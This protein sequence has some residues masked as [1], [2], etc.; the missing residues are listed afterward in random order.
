MEARKKTDLEHAKLLGPVKQVMETCYKAHLR[1]GDV[2]QGKIESDLAH[3]SK[4]N[5]KTYNENGAK[6]HEQLFGSDDM[7][8]NTF[9][10]EGHQTESIHYRNGKL[11]TTST[12]TFNEHGN[13][14]DH[15]VR[16][17]DGSLYFQVIS[18]Y[19][20]K[21]KPLESIHYMGD[22]RKI[23]SRNI[24]TY[25]ENGDMLTHIEYNGEGKITHQTIKTYNKEGKL[26]D[27]NSEYTEEKKFKYN[28]RTT[29]KYN[30]HGDTIETA[31]HK[32]D[33]SIDSVFRYSYT[34]NKL[35]QCI[36][37]TSYD[38]DGS[39][40]YVTQHE[41]DSEGKRII[42]PYEYDPEG[43]KTPGE[44]DKRELDAHGNW[45]KKTTFY[46]KLP[47]N[48]YVRQ[49]NYFGEKQE[50]FVH[51]LA[52]ATDEEKENKVNPPAELEDEQ[53]QW[54]VAGSPQPETFAAHRYYTIVHKE[55]PSVLNYPSSYIE[56][57]A[58]L[59]VLK[60]NLGAVEI[61][62]TLYG[63]NAHFSNLAS[64]TLSF[65]GRPYILQVTEIQ[66]EDGEQ[67]DVPQ[68]IK[69]NTYYAES[70]D[71]YFGDVELLMPSAASG[72]RD[73]YFENELHEYTD[74]CMVK[75]KPDKPT[76]RMIE[77]RGNAFAMVE[78]ALNDDF[79]IKD[80]DINY[81]YGFE[82][83][84]E[85]LMQRFATQ[86]K[87][88]VLFHGEPGTGKTFYIRHL[89]RKMVSRKKIVIYMPP[90]MVDHLVEP[91]FMTF[92]A[93][94]IQTWSN[95]GFFS[96]LLIEDAEPLLAKRQEG[97]RIQGVT[98]LLNMTDGLLND[99][100]NLQI[101]CTFNVDLKK[102]DSALLRPGRLI[103]RKEFKKLSEL[104]ANLLAQRLGIKHNFKKGATL[105]EIYAML[106]NKNTLI[107]DVEPDKDASK[108]I[109]DF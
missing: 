5:I 40:S 57:F 8:I 38:K 80:L 88:L 30:E 89:L 9:N 53:L 49:I 27:D 97:V 12:N 70:R 45:I 2:I 7:Y 62:S 81:G 75:K 66:D 101:I 63:S 87:G 82:K 39:S 71:L 1:G 47:I 79:E 41:Y 24:Y 52:N 109:D 83:F 91:A 106:K 94:Q 26:I 103:A 33:G 54:L 28:R 6:I 85:E 19:F 16:K 20:A 108:L 36:E 22:E 76:I 43:E 90:N 64:Y 96:V 105:G 95:Q 55:A 17:A 4:N 60:E 58:L 68:N 51:P 73:S 21:H 13:Q 14:I 46:N 99:M 3:S 72:K 23:L 44:T 42:V 11:D 100:L 32:Y 29:H 50:D 31:F 61:H 84:H 98:N 69:E 35:G 59:H 18:K 86:S 77:V 10:E 37:T 56:A 15:T 107:H 78:H 48:T 92:L 65:P 93:G 34:Y 25:N 104:D 67:F 74:L 102:L